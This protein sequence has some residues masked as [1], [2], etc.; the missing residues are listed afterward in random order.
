M[1]C[2]LKTITHWA[3]LTHIFKTF[4]I[5]QVEFVFSK[6]EFVVVCLLKGFVF[7]FICVYCFK[8]MYIWSFMYADLGLSR[9][10]FPCKFGYVKCLYKTYVEVCLINGLH[11]SFVYSL[12]HWRP[13]AFCLKVSG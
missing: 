10:L 6:F 12:C 3:R 5:F 8:I 7:S 9:S 1:K 2:C 11:C 4:S 13:F